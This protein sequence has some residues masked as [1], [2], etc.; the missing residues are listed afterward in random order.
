MADPDDQVFGSRGDFAVDQ[1]LTQLVSEGFG[2]PTVQE[3]GGKF[4][5]LGPPGRV[6]G[7]GGEV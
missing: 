3:T 1:D 2:V 5:E 6:G 4:R 7:M